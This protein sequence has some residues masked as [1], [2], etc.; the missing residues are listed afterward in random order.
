MDILIVD[1][2]NIFRKHIS[3]ALMRRGYKISSAENGAEAVCMAANKPFDAALIDMKMPGMDG[4][5]VITELKEIQPKLMGIILTGYGSIPTAVKAMKIGAY[6]YLTKPC[7]IEEIEAVLKVAYQ[8][9][10]LDT[11]IN[12]DS[13]S[14]RGYQGIV[15]NNQKMRKVID[16]IQMVKDSSFP[17]LICGESGTGK[18]LVARAIH[19]DSIR[20]E[21]P[22]IPV[23]CASLKPELLENE[24]F[25]H[26]KGAFTGATNSKDGLLKVADGGTL[27]I[28]EIADMNPT[29]QASL[30]RFLET[31][32]FRPLGSTRELKVD[33]RIVAAINRDIE[34]E[35]K[36]KRFRHDLYYRL[37][38]CRI[39]IPPLRDR[40]EDIPLLVRHFLASSPMARENP[41]TISPG[42]MDVLTACPWPGNVRELFNTL[43]RAML[44]SKDSTITKGLIN[45]ILP[46]PRIL[47][48]IPQDLSLDD[49]KKRHI[50]ESLKANRWNIS[51]TAKILGIDRR[52]LQRKI[53]CYQISK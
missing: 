27:F 20:K 28:D 22:F 53:A 1:D 10:V 21:G 38:V 7:E 39:N 33:V 24:L 51:R 3:K 42:A 34:E 14:S 29:V 13:S 31:G 16:A 37:N 9:R 48:T 23:N 11:E 40:K 15:G 41:I 52:T 4:I 43:S 44:F 5:H 6:N 46:L 8:E 32:I 45:S 17:V 36:A 19:F 12:I 26:V 2:D 30:L 47:N 50:I 18:E 25:G 35:V 49:I